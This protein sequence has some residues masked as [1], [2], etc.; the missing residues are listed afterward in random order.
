MNATTIS[1]DGIH[2]QDLEWKIAMERFWAT[3]LCPLCDCE[4]GNVTV[5]QMSSPSHGGEI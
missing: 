5:C 4:H 3:G 2:A 1:H